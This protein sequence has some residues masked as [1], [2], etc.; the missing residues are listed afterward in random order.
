MASDDASGGGYWKWAGLGFE[1]TGVVGLFFYFG[2]LVDEHWGVNPWGILTGGAI[3]VVGGTY[4]LARE[5]FKMMRELDQ[6]SSIE[7][8]NDNGGPERPQ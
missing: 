3:G 4:W 1:F 2:Y 5:G 6:P 7:N 8:K